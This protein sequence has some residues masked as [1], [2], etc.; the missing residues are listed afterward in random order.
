MEYGH[1]KSKENLPVDDDYDEENLEESIKTKTAQSTPVKPPLTICTPSDSQE[2]V[3]PV[4]EQASATATHTWLDDGLLSV[5]PE[6]GVHPILE[7]IERAEKEWKGKLDNASKTLDEAVAEY[8]RRY[9][10]KPPLGFDD[11]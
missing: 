11:W 8:K 2:D 4:E 5:N 1:V 7:L 3:I 6:S 10:R 9:G